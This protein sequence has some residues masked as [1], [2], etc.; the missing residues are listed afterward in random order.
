LVIATAV[1]AV[2][3]AGHNALAAAAQG[4]YSTFTGADPGEGLDFQG[5]FP[6]ALDLAKQASDPTPT[7][8]DAVFEHTYPIDTSTSPQTMFQ[9]P[10]VSTGG[11]TLKGY[12]YNS[13]VGVGVPT[14]GDTPADDALESVMNTTWE[15]GF[16]ISVA[17]GT[18]GQ[19]LTAGQGYKL[20]LFGLADNAP[21]PRDTQI[22][23]EGINR[24]NFDFADTGGYTTEGGVV[25]YSFNA[26]DNFDGGF[27]HGNGF[28]DIAV[29]FPQDGSNIG[30][31]GGL[32]LET[33]PQLPQAESNWQGS[34]SGDWTDQSR[35]DEHY[36]NA[37][38]AIGNFFDGATAP[39]TVFTD[40]P[41]T[42]GILRFNNAF[43]Y[44]ITG[45]GSLTMSVTSGNALIDV[46]GGPQKINLPLTIA[47]DTVVQVAEGASLKISDPLTISAGQSLTQSGTGTVTYESTIDVQDG[48]SIAFGSTS[49]AASLSLAGAATAS[50]VQG[51][52]KVLVLDHLASAGG[53][54]AWTSQIDVKDNDMIVRSSGSDRAAQAAEI[55]NQ[56]KQGA[57]FANAGQFWTGKGMITSLGGNG[58][59]SY[60]AVGVAIND[61]ATLGGAQT[62]AL[63]STFD[64]QDVGVNDVLVKYTYFGDADLDGAVTT[65]DYFQIDNG[66]LGS[67]TGWINGDF[68]YDG[69]VTTNDYFLIDN[70]FL[71]QGSALVPAALGS[72]Q[73][74]SGVTAVPEPASLGV[75]AFAAAAALLRRR[76]NH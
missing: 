52:G 42:A 48:A 3:G 24:G 34:S 36:P 46:Q 22:Y 68:D 51:G 65:N 29:V 35:W 72:A 60:T 5:T 43:G 14:Y 63:Y 59:T 15:P 69:A 18:S 2:C 4:T 64:G 12:F 9:P 58:S 30:F 53:S 39:R 25:T 40:V 26:V 50:I 45:Q 6:L 37:S 10:G 8:G 41:I 73:P 70:A 74:L 13:E 19:R 55:T 66:F 71:G 62:G 75:F 20:Q 31:V 57:N 21:L 27:N 7:I 23:V 49:H 16:T 54:D 33:A 44:Q 17:V 76:R 1:L 11:S 47:S 28:I 61:F 67:K 56:L 32:T 38:D